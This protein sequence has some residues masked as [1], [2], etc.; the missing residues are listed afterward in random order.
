MQWRCTN[1]DRLQFQAFRRP[2][3]QLSAADLFNLPLSE[4]FLVLDLR[5]PAAYQVAVAAARQSAGTGLSSS[6]WRNPVK[7]ESV[8]RMSVADCGQ[9]LHISDSYCSELAID[10]SSLV[11]SL[12]LPQRLLDLCVSPG[13]R[14]RQPL[15]PFQCQHAHATPGRG[16]RLD[17]VADED[18]PEQK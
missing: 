15:S 17:F 8:W 16:C 5:G 4:S 14:R 2:V 12:N 3:V 1:P 13:Q 10:G 11:E 18:P 7:V 9:A 6:P